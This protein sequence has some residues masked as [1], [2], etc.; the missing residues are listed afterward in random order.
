MS[1]LNVL[2]SLSDWAIM[3]TVGVLTN[4]SPPQYLPLGILSDL[5]HLEEHLGENRLG[6]EPWGRQSVACFT[7]TM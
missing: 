2:T 4:F 3:C 6:V 1:A 5:V 7:L